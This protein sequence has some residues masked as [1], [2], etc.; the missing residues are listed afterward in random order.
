MHIDKI[1]SQQK[2]TQL[3][4]KRGTQYPVPRGY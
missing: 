2:A 3:N 4:A 1:Y